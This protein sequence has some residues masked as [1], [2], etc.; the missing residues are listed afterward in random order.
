MVL[1]HSQMFCL[2]PSVEATGLNLKDI[3]EVFTILKSLQYT[4]LVW[5][6]TFL[7]WQQLLLEFCAQFGESFCQ[8]L[9]F[10]E[11]PASRVKNLKLF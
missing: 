9:S 3:T 1:I 4:S 11:T 8:L 7:S 2:L 10:T 6:S 5:G